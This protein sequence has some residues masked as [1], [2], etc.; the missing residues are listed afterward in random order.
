M[1]N[2]ILEL[3]LLSSRSHRSGSHWVIK[4]TVDLGPE[5][6]PGGSFDFFQSLRTTIKNN[7]RFSGMMKFYK[8]EDFEGKQFPFVVNIFPKKIGPAGDF[9]QGMMM[10]ADNIVD[11]DKPEEGVPILFQLQK[12]VPNGTKVR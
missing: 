12:K 11:K 6:A 4:L 8:P 10:A 1:Q 9:S 7:R 3:A 5:D 2:W